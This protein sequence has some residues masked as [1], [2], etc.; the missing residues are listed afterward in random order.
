[1]SEAQVITG[2]E[3]IRCFQMRQQLMA[4]YAEVQG[5]RHSSGRSINAHIKRTYGIKG[6][7]KTDVYKAFHALI[8]EKEA[9]AGIEARPLNRMEKKIL[10]E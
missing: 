4:L 6:R 1:M 8:L 3:R 9:E 2:E 10:G 5:M 7:K